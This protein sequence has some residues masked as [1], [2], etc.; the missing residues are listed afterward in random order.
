MLQDCTTAATKDIHEQTLGPYRRNT[1]CR[2]LRVMP[3]SE[4]MAELLEN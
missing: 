4:L 1:R 3:S 2:L